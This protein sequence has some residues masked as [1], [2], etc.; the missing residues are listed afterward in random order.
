MKTLLRRNLT[1]MILICW[2]TVFLVLPNLQPQGVA[3]LGQGVTGNGVTGHGK[4]VTGLETTGPP[5]NCGVFSTGKLIDLASMSLFDKEN[6]LNRFVACI[7]ANS[8]LDIDAF[9]FSS[10]TIFGWSTGK[11]TGLMAATTLGFNNIAR[12]LIHYDAN[13]NVR[14]EYGH[15]SL[16]CAAMAG[17]NNMIGIL[18]GLGADVNGVEAYGRTP[19]H[20]AAY[21][22][23][24]STVRFLLERGADINVRGTFGNGR[25]TALETASYYGRTNVVALLQSWGR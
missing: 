16:L 3:R 6:M 19:L 11:Q 22:G 20:V 17:N 7:G 9:Y 18:L 10:I 1:R 12:T 13:I 23:H 4:G 5:L 14:N 8:V 15:T 25:L 21:A 24:V 2:L